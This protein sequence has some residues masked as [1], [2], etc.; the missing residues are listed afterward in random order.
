MLVCFVTKLFISVLQL[1]TIQSHV[2]IL[3]FPITGQ[4]GHC[5]MQKA[6]CPGM[7]VTITCTIHGQTHHWSI[8]DQNIARSLSVGNLNTTVRDSPFQFTVT[9]VGPNGSITEITAST[10]AVNFNEHL[11]G[12][13]V[14]CWD[15]NQSPPEAEQKT[16]MTLKGN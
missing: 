9:E 6:G 15:G 7:N 11:D 4:C 14:S 3:C 13:S 8:P 2:H 12:V 10:A 1:T 16:T 5:D